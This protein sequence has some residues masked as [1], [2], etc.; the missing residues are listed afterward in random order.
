MAGYD[1]NTKK[2][3]ALILVVMLSLLAQSSFINA[4]TNEIQEQRTSTSKHYYLGTLGDGRYKYEIVSSIAPLHYKDDRGQWQDIDVQDTVADSGLYAVKFTSLPYIVRI[5]NDSGRRIYPDR[6]DLSYWV[7]LGKPFPNMGLPV[8]VGR[9]WTWDFANAKLEI[10]IGRTMVKL[11]ALLKNGDAP[12]SLTFP[13]SA[14]GLIREGNLLKHNGEVV[15]VLHLPVA[16]DA[17]GVERQLNVTWNSGSVTVSLNTSGLTYPI[18]IDP[19][20]D[21]SVAAS[22]D[23]DTVYRVGA[24]FWSN[25][26]ITGRVGYDFAGAHAYGSSMRFTGINIPAGATI[27]STYL[28]VIATNTLSG[29]TV[30]SD[31]AFENTSN[32]GQM[33]SYADHTGRTRTTPV[34]YDGVPAYTAGNTYNTIDFSTALQQVVDDNG[35]TGDAVIAFWEDKDDQSDAFAIRYYASYDNVTYDPPAIHIEYTT[36]APPVTAST[37]SGSAVISPP[38]LPAIMK[39]IGFGLTAFILLLA[40]WKKDP[41]IYFVAAPVLVTFGMGWHDTYETPA[42]FTF[43]VAMFGLGLYSLT[44]GGLHLTGRV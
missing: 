41:F 12:S 7:D 35:G 25:A 10:I 36:A 8:K 16:V 38:A 37:V 11:N 22:A 17:L 43:S 20:L 44:L 29:G 4:Q 33:A 32:P 5:G 6:N 3:S 39:S 40:F 30:R 42:G 2:C 9:A 19:T 14:T 15:A 34:T 28:T 18:T 21:I 26:L 23:D 24:S 13:F 27:D 31:L 1:V